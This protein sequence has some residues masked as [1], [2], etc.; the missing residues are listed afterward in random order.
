MV[1]VKKKNQKN[2]KKKP[3]RIF[4]VS[5]EVVLGIHPDLAATVHLPL[6]LCSPA[7]KPLAIRAYE[8]LEIS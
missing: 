8:E 5:T 2:Y 1:S 6:E 7:C 4:N 3:S